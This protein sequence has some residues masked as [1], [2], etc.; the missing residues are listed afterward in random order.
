[1]IPSCAGPAPSDAINAGSTQYAISLA[2]SFRK[3]VSP[4]T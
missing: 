2:V 3:D 1:M 4:K